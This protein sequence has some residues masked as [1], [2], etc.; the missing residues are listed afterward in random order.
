VNGDGRLDIYV[1]KAGSGKPPERANQLWIARGPGADGVPRFD[2]RAREYGVADEGWSTH[3][4]F[5][6][7]DRDGDLDL[8]VVNNS[9]RPVTGFGVFYARLTPDRYGGAKFYRNDGARFVEVTEQAGIY[10]P[11][12]AFGLGVAVGDVNRDGGRTSTS[13]TTST[14]ATTCTSTRGTGR[15]PSRSTARC[16]R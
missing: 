12:T 8:L 1:S 14:S 16:R 5:L 9:P 13:P 15:S 7:H 4:A 10:S 6:D 11:E 2:E 3:A